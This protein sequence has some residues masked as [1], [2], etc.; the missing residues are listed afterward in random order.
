ME[1]QG[2]ETRAARLDAQHDSAPGHGPGMPKQQEVPESRSSNVA[3]GTDMPAW[4]K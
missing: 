4:V 1:A 2:G 3:W